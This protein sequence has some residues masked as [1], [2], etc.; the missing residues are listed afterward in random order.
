MIT[1]AGASVLLGATILALVHARRSPVDQ[2]A[3]LG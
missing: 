3:G 1:I 2:P